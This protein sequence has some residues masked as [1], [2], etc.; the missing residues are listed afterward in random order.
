MATMPSSKSLLT[1]TNHMRHYVQNNTILAIHRSGVRRMQ[2]CTNF[3]QSQLL[4]E[5]LSTQQDGVSDP[6]SLFK[7]EYWTDNMTIHQNIPHI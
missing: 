5:N 6:G 7:F 3:G 4:I 1:I 2:E